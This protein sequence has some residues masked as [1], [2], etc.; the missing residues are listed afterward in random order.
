MNATLDAPEVLLLMPPNA[1]M[2][3]LRYHGG[4]GRG[5]VELELRDH[6]AVRVDGECE[7]DWPRLEEAAVRL[8]DAFRPGWTLRAGSGSLLIN[9][10]SGDA[11]IELDGAG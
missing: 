3:R 5:R 11:R 8:L 10:E 6:L 1:A 9:A 7:C 2:L 4:E